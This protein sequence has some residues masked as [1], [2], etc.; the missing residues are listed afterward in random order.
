MCEHEVLGVFDRHD[1]RGRAPSF[2]NHDA[3]AGFDT[4]DHLRGRVL[5]LFDPDLSHAH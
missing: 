3:L 5:E 2:H 4:L 1:D